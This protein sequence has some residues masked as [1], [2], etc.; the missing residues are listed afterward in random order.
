MYLEIVTPEASL[1]QG[2]VESLT[3]PGTDG[4]FQMLNNHAAIVSSLGKG[5]VA[6]SGNP[7]FMPAFKDRFTQKDGKWLLPISSGTVQMVDN[8]VIVLAD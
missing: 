8:K 1:V 2:E 5:I 7:E 4:E 6:F 3:V